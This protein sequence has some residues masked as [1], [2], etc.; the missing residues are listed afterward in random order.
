M[1]PPQANLSEFIMSTEPLPK[2]FTPDEWN[3]ISLS[4]GWTVALSDRTPE[5]NHRHAVSMQAMDAL[6]RVL[7]DGFHTRIVAATERPMESWVLE[8]AARSGE[9]K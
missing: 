2:P 3:A 4:I 5:G 8:L 6:K 9:R 7:G 1:P